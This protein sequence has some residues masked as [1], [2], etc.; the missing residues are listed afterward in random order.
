MIHVKFAYFIAMTGPVCMNFFSTMVG[1]AGS[2][3]EIMKR[4][5]VTVPT[6][7]SLQLRGQAMLVHWESMYI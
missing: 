7:V 3:I 6:A 4:Q 5:P 1:K 2:T